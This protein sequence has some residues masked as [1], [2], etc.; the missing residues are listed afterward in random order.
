MK[1]IKGY[2]IAF[3]GL[4][5]GKHQFDFV[6]NKT[7]LQHFEGA[8]VSDAKVNIAL[9]LEKRPG[10]MT[11]N[12]SLEGTVRSICDV[13]TEEF[14]LPIEGEE[15]LTVKIVDQIPANTDEEVDVIYLE[16]GSSTLH[17]AKVLYELLI[18]SLPMRNAHPEDED[19]NR[20]CN[21]EVL[22][23]LQESEENELNKASGEEADS[24]SI[25]TAL[26]SLK[27]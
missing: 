5:D 22:K 3:A 20:N 23:F 18:L 16:R 17:L 26:K 10:F 9:S 12:L 8:L 6:L 25:W 27:K 15:Q 24:S 11:L 19:G 14:D 21:P 2:S 13:C 4:P 7:F 1:H